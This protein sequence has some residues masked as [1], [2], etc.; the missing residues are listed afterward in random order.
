MIDMYKMGLVAFLDLGIG[1]PLNYVAPKAEYTK[2]DFEKECDAEAD[3]YYSF[4]EVKE[5]WCKYYE[6]AP[7]GIDIDGGCFGFCNKAEQGAFEVWYVDLE[8]VED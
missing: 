1:T 5:G 4:G 6:E 3:G 7:E 8:E 2:D